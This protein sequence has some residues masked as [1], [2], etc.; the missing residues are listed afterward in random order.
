M[1]KVSAGMYVTNIK[2]NT[3]AKKVGDRKS[4]V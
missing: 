2:A 4:V 1:N 3:I